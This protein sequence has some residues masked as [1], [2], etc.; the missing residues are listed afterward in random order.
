MPENNV[1]CFAGKLHW[2]DLSQHIVTGF[3]IRLCEV[4]VKGAVNSSVIQVTHVMRP[5]PDCKAARV[6]RH[7]IYKDHCRQLSRCM[8][9][10]GGQTT[11]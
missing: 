7:R 1:P 3:A 4:G 9:S 2:R 6:R 8:V 10:M 5:R 11:F